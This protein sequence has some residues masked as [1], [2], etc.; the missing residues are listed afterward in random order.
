MAWEMQ[1]PMG[2]S[3]S[4]IPICSLHPEHQRKGIGT[5]LMGRLMAKY[6][7]FHQHIL[8]ADDKAVEFYQ[9]CGFT[10]AGKTEPMWI[11]AGDCWR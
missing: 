3:L 11:Y 2:I 9:K 1:F 6:R 10:R 4:T 5:E 8:V 7:S